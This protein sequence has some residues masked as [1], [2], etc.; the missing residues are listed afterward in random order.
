MM[1]RLTFVDENGEVLFHPAELPEDEGVTI[2]NLAENNRF[3]ELE[4]IAVRLANLEQRIEPYEDLGLEPSQLKEISPMYQ[5]K[6]EEVV[7]LKKEVA[8]LKATNID[9]IEM[10]KIHIGLEKLKE[11]QQKLAD[12]RMVELPELI[13]DTI[14]EWLGEI[15]ES[16]KLAYDTK[17]MAI[18]E[19]IAGELIEKLKESEEK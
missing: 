19:E 6:C 8:M 3:E 12:G 16:L 18:F 1:E 15:E 14:V 17:S 10:C 7:A 9:A 11:Y 13:I 2:T 4:Q 5:A